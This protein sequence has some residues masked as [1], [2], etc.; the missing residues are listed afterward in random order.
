M[1]G[2]ARQGKA[3]RGAAR[4]GM[5]GMARH[6]TAGMARQGMARPGTARQGTAGMEKEKRWGGAAVPPYQIKTM[7]TKNSRDKGGRRKSRGGVRGWGPMVSGGLFTTQ[8]RT[9]E[10][11]LSHSDE[12]ISLEVRRKTK[13]S[14]NC[15]HLVRS[16]G[17]EF[18]AKSKHK[19]QP[20]K[21]L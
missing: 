5:A 6:G 12:R 2:M 17:D 4:Q 21:K 11:T 14:G 19:N 15:W 8:T 3:G 18:T 9:H 20:R 16:L 13:P 10:I 1:A 7:I